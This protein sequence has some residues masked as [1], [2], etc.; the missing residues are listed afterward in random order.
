MLIV[1][2]NSNKHA[3]RSYKELTVNGKKNISKGKQRHAELADIFICMI[4]SY[5]TQEMSYCN[6]RLHQA[7][8]Q[9]I[10][11]STAITASSYNH[12]K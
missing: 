3:S 4:A 7:Y 9:Y 8:K 10:I 1:L 6:S 11:S 2:L 12:P 5:H